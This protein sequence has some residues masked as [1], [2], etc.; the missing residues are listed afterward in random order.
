MKLVYPT[1]FPLFFTNFIEAQVAE[2]D[3]PESCYY[4]LDF[5]GDDWG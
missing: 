3:Q 4:A 2:A 1:V 5:G